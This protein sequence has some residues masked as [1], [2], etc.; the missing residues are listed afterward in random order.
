[1]VPKTGLEPAHPFER[2]ALNTVCLPIPPPGADHLPSIGLTYA[3]E[4]ASYA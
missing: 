2:G 4:S 3:Q 1:M